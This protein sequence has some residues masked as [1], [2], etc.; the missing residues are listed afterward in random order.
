MSYD[1]PPALPPGEYVVLKPD[2]EAT[3]N[4]SLFVL[5][6][7]FRKCSSSGCKIKKLFFTGSFQ[8]K[9]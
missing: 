3:G 8:I 7:L 4:T 2:T 1:E 6:N 5:D 9:R